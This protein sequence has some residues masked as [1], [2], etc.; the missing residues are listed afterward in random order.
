MFVVFPK[1]MLKSIINKIGCERLKF[2]GY[3]SKIKEVNRSYR[4]II[5]YFNSD[6]NDNNIILYI[7][8]IENL[9]SRS[10]R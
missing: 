3:S 2:P 5:Y 6:N 8:T 1:K 7:L 4:I 10:N 9:S